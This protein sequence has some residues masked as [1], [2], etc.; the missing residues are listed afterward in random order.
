MAGDL[1]FFLKNSVHYYGVFCTQYDTVNPYTDMLTAV[2]KKYYESGLK[3]QKLKTNK[4]L[5]DVIYRY[6]YYC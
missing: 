1:T 3:T 2:R 5:N 6:N 4:R